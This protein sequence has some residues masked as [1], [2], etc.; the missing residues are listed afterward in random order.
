MKNETKEY[1]VKGIKV[2]IYGILIFFGSRKAKNFFNG[3]NK[4]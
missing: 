2:V 4:A 1:I 3:N